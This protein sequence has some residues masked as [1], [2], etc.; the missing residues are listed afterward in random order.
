MPSCRVHAKLIVPK[1]QHVLGMDWTSSRQVAI[2][3]LLPELQG[4][5]PRRAVH[6]D[7]PSGTELGASAV[8]STWRQDLQL[9]PLHFQWQPLGDQY[10]AGLA[11]NAL[12]VLTTDCRLAASV[13]VTSLSG[14]CL[15][16][17]WATPGGQAAVN[18]CA[19]WSM[20]VSVSP[21]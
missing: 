4:I 15:C 9:G 13:P 1:H 19:M 6:T 12:L 18:L 5:L 21:F 10:L 16:C 3:F 14:P 2:T 17:H 7:S 11:D 20:L 8:F